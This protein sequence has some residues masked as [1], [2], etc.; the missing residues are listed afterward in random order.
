MR[1]SLYKL[2]VLV[3]A[4]MTSNAIAASP[5]VTQ[6]PPGLDQIINPEGPSGSD[7]VSAVR[8]MLL[9]NMGHTV[10]FRGGMAQESY[11]LIQ[12]L[13][14]ES[15]SLDSMFRFSTIIEPSGALPPVIVEAKDIAH[16][17]GNQIRTAN[18][19]YKIVKEEE[20]VSVP[21]TWRDYLFTGLTVD[22]QASYPGKES[23][24][25]SSAEKAIWESSVKSGWDEGVKAADD[26]AEANFNRLTRDY[27]GMMRYSVLLHKGMI[28]HTVVAEEV[29]G[30]TTSSKQLTIGETRKQLT[31]SAEFQQNPDLWTPEV[32][33]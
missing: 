30:V 14:S 4:F 23:Q 2:S 28:D 15:A 12:K 24:P 25:N 8:R 13:K 27:T 20:F 7:N 18:K 19:V 10:G 29:K 11:Y 31:K 3:V 6:S 9:S 1:T 33:R 21:P 26:I 5:D 17:T 16:I 32:S 22:N